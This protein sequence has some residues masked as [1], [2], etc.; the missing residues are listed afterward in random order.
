MR[1]HSS[2][3]LPVALSPEPSQ[4]RTRQGLE[5]LWQ[6]EKQ[7]EL[8]MQRTFHKFSHLHALDCEIRKRLKK[9]QV[10]NIQYFIKLFR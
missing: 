9:F 1:G 8:E 10:K 3:A 7:L 6:R 5:G 4:M 2:E